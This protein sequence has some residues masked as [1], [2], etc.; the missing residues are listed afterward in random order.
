MKQ[1][2]ALFTWRYLRGTSSQTT[3]SL[4][5]KI[6]FVAIFIATFALTL[7][8]CIMQGFEKITHEKLRGIN[9]PIIMR[10]YG[11]ELNVAQIQRV[12]RAEFP[13]IIGITPTTF[14]QAIIQSASCNDITHV[15][16]LKAI[17]PTTEPSVSC[18]H[19][20][21]RRKRTGT[22]QS[23]AALF[24]DHSL[25]IGDALAQALAV[26][27]GDPVTIVSLD[28]A[29]SS[30]NNIAFKSYRA[31]VAATF[32]TGI[33]EFDT[34]ILVCSYGFFHTL[35]PDAGVT[36][37]NINVAPATDED[38]LAHKL[39]NRF[40]IDIA[41]WKEL[42]PALVSALTLEK[43]AMLFILILILL[44]ACTNIIALEFM[45]IVHKRADIAILKAMGAQHTLLTT[46]FMVFGV[47]IA[48]CATTAGLV[49]AAIA[50]YLL[51]HYPFIKLP[52]AY[53][54]A[55]SQLPVSMDW[56]I[57]VFVFTLVMVLSSIATWIP[58]RGIRT[59][60]LATLLRSER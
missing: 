16:A 31:L 24:D 14:N 55:F 17:D 52:D 15:I 4:L 59:M 30:H 43:Y 49:C 18:L 9:A 2:I 35:F 50:C 10:A 34:N 39:R 28:Q 46:L 26:Q 33:D 48:L 3:L 56:Q 13:E 40:G 27:P 8:V 20:K 58:T 5:V 7:I 11:D 21:I 45:H 53:C 60:T 44:V 36:Q 1:M 38:A 54:V 19:Q 22:S 29:R 25:L 32:T 57:F 12:L 42:Y 23:F 51:D 37:L 6:C 47:S 41:S